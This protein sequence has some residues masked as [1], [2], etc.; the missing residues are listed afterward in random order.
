MRTPSKTIHT[1][2]ELKEP[3]FFFFF[4]MSFILFK[5]KPMVFLFSGLVLYSASSSGSELLL[6]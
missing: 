2:I 5:P 6:Q 1:N 4:R 3:F